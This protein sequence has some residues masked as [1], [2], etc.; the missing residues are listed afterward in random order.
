MK[1]EPYMDRLIGR[2]AILLV[3]ES[4]YGIT[5]WSGCK[6]NINKN[7]L[8]L[9]YLPSGKPY[10]IKSELIEFDVRFGSLL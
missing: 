10:F 1:R 6:F 5:T 9:R 3:F 4:M 8:P 2:K 7:H